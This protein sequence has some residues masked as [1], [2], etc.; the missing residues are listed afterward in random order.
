M[1]F[2]APEASTETQTLPLHPH[3]DEQTIS[4]ADILRSG[5]GAHGL[6]QSSSFESSGQPMP[7]GQQPEST[8]SSSP[9]PVQM[10]HVVTLPFQASLRPQ[11]DATLVAQKVD[12]TSF[13]KV[14]TSEDLIE[15]EPALV[16][17]IDSL[18]SKLFGL[19]DYPQDVIGTVLEDL[20]PAEQIKYACNANSKIC[21]LF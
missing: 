8:S 18:F 9:G 11:Y 14:F 6:M 21:F 2:T 4:P 3:G 15:P 13:G 10:Q 5:S 7:L 12:V 16:E 20:A 17:K 1:A 19:C